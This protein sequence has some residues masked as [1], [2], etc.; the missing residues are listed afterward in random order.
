MSIFVTNIPHSNKIAAVC[1]LFTSSLL[2]AQPT[3]DPNLINITTLEQLDAIRFDLNGDGQVDNAANATAYSAAFGT[4][5]CAGSCTG[6]ELTTNLD[7]R[8]GSTDPA[9]YSI[10]A[11][12]STASGALTGGWAPIGDNSAFQ[13]ASLPCSKA[14]TTR[15][16]TSTSIAL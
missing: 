8:N 11:E 1:L 3:D 12:G 4:P 5:S 15:S 2:A 10:W 6:Y 9:D 7:F 13:V 16:P 14:T